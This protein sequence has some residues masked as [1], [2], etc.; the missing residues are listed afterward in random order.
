MAHPCSWDVLLAA[1][2]RQHMVQGPLPLSSCTQASLVQGAALNGEHGHGLEEQD[3]HAACFAARSQAQRTFP[4][5]A[6]TCRVSAPVLPSAR[7]GF[8][9]GPSTLNSHFVGE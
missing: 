1:S 4:A 8:H 2:W 9:R 5:A 6:G 3:S 7:V